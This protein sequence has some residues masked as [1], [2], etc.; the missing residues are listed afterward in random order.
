MN[1]LLISVVFGV[2]QIMIWNVF[3]RW[4]TRFMFNI[5]L[6][7]IAANILGSLVI[8]AIAGRSAFVGSANLTGSI[9]FAMYAFFKKGELNEEKTGF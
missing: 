6:L 7:A 4:F 8:V 9:L 2:V 3:P 5:P 1:F